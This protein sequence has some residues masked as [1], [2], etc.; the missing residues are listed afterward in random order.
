MNQTEVSQLILKIMFPELLNTIYMILASTALSAIFG[1]ILAIALIT[2]AP[3]GLKP[4]AFVHRCL[5][6]LI[7]GIR[8]FPFIILI[9]A[10]IPITRLIVGTSIGVNAAIV[11]L[12]IS[13][14]AFIAR[15]MESNLQEVDSALIEAAQSFGASNFQIIFKVIIPEAFPSLV[16]GVTIAVIAILGNTAM[17]GAVGAGGLGAVAISYGYANFNNT[18]MYST[19]VILIIL[20]ILIQSLG[21]FLYKRLK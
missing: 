11:P 17:A 18:I 6:I 10:I 3:K 20:V 21:N 1:M 16:S 5:D 8:S 13:G 7:N 9:V 15:I 2:T 4:Q 19:V 14:S 12:V